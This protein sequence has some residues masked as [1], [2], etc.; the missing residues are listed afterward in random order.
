MNLIHVLLVNDSLLI[1]RIIQKILST[2][3]LFSPVDWVKDG[4][5]AEE[6]VQKHPPDIIL[7]DIHMPRQNGVET[8]RKIL[9]T[10]HIPILVVT[11]TVSRNMSEIFQC[12][13]YGALEAVK[14]PQHEEFKNIDTLSKKELRRKGAEFI[15]KVKT[16]A[17]LKEKVLLKKMLPLSVPKES[18]PIYSIEHASKPASYLI[19]IGASTGGPGALSQL[20]RSIPADIS[21]AIVIVQHI[22]VD[23]I[24]SLIG[25]IQQYCRLPVRE[26]VEGDIP[27]I[28]CVYLAGKKEK[29]LKCDAN[30]RFVYHN[31]P[32]FIHMPSINVLFESVAKNYQQNA[33]GV[34]LTG[35]GADGAKGLKQMRDMG[36]FTLA[37]DKDSSLIYGM[38]QVAAKLNACDEIVPLQQMGDRIVRHIK[39][40]TLFSNSSKR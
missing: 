17:S 12:I 39:R 5:E 38:P 13:Q 19:A 2:E 31:K 25:Y 20:L 3:P 23:F 10:H 7:M 30:K 8:I 1:S 9:A 22:D 18:Q 37:Q 6:Y 29:H 27:E 28:G 14:P 21:A 26:A 35:M 11:A 34:L 40:S 33:V 16:I 4:V 24:P 15:S 36:G 32:D